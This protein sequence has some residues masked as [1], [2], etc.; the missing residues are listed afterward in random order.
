[1]SDEL[2]LMETK[3]IYNLIQDDDNDANFIKES[4]K[5]LTALDDALMTTITR[6]L[7]RRN[8]NESGLI[9]WIN[10]A[11]LHRRPRPEPIH[12]RD[13]IAFLLDNNQYLSNGGDVYDV[14][15]AATDSERYALISNNHLTR[16]GIH[17]GEHTHKQLDTSKLLWLKDKYCPS[18]WSSSS[19]VCNKSLENSMCEVS[20]VSKKIFK[21]ISTKRIH[22]T[23]ELGNYNYYFY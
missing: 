17:E 9:I 14:F 10:P 22:A 1:M 8:T 23:E 12:L 5:K 13:T 20:N 18:G 21:D 3:I 15:A 11:Y 7:L 19:T 2:K 16:N 6:N 4:R